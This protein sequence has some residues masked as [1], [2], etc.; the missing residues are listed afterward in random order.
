MSVSTLD[1]KQ[2]DGG[3]FAARLERKTTGFE[4]KPSGPRLVDTKQSKYPSNQN[5]PT[6]KLHLVEQN[7]PRVITTKRTYDHT[8]FEPGIAQRNP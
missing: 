7:T 3:T 4:S 5:K 2:G 1:R 8:S 6:T